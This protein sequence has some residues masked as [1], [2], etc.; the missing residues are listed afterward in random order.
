MPVRQR[1]IAVRVVQGFDVGLGLGSKL[2][3]FEGVGAI[4]DAVGH[5]AGAMVP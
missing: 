5:S 2:V 3:K 1:K 4:Q